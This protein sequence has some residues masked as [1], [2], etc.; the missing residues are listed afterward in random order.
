MR[1]LFRYFPYRE[2]Q[3]LPARFCVPTHESGERSLWMLEP[4][5]FS[6]ER[7]RVIGKAMNK[8]TKK[9]GFVEVNVCRFW[10]GDFDTWEYEPRISWHWI[11]DKRIR[12]SA[13]ETNKVSR[14]S[15]Q[16][17][18]DVGLVGK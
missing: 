14:M 13:D 9:P 10:F 17:L 3:W 8:Q 15:L 6:E 16:T 4:T 7:R 18:V 12:E 1:D 11:T 5:N 2:L